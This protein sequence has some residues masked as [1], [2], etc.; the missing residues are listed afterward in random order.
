MRLL[1]GQKLAR[2]T[3]LKG[4]TGSAGFTTG[5]IGPGPRAAQNHERE[6]KEKQKRKTKQKEQ[7]TKKELLNLDQ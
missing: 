2:F 6:K 1:L 4:H 7:R 5:P 3:Q